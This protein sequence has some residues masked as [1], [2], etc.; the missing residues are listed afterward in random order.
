ML[1]LCVSRVVTAA[2]SELGERN[3]A[4]GASLRVGAALLA[5]RRCPPGRLDGW[6][7]WLAG[8]LTACQFAEWMAGWLAG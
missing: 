3:E 5:L 1:R 7:G 4:D 2:S 6:T 8:S